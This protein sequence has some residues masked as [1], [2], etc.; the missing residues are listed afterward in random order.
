MGKPMEAASRLRCGRGDP[1][2]RVR[3]TRVVSDPR[4]PF[5]LRGRGRLPGEALVASSTSNGG[6][7]CRHGLCNDP[8]GC[9]DAGVQTEAGMVFR[10]PRSMRANSSIPGWERAAA[11]YAGTFAH[12]SGGYI[13]ALARR[14]PAIGEG[15]SGLLDLACG[16]G[17]VT[18]AAAQRGAVTPTRLRFLRRDAA[19]MA[20]AAHPDLT[21]SI[22]AM[23]RR[24]PMRTAPS[25]RSCR[26]SG[27]T[28]FPAP[29]NAP[30]REARRVLRPG[31]RLP[32]FTS[33]AE[34]G[35]QHRL[36][37]AVRRPRASRRSGGGQNPALG[38]RA[39]QDRGGAGGAEWRRV[40]RCRRRVPS[41]ATGSSPTRPGD[42]VA[43][44]RRGTVRTAAL[45][46]AQDPAAMPAI[47]A[48]IERA[49][50]AYRR[51]LGPLRR[52]RSSR[53]SPAAAAGLT[54]AGSRHR[55]P[56]R[57]RRWGQD[58]RGALCG[59]QRAPSACCWS[60]KAS[61][62]AAGRRSWRR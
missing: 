46:E 18:R 16:P 62:A 13:E 4:G 5:R 47:L 7:A 8:E 14:P 24:C 26:I 60:T 19:R 10:S 1:V 39:R 30:P 11:A 38:R 17:L 43:S 31:R 33:W 48:H 50:A 44:L 2:R 29:P 61:S 49:V 21:L 37:A 3:S 52:S 51:C 9:A 54:R 12:A 59:A 36:A 25:T 32:A 28:I 35:A 20:R 40:C 42:L 6:K 56:D 23:P 22:R 34:P 45:I 53:S 27:C 57:R 41:S 58:V 15:T 55:H